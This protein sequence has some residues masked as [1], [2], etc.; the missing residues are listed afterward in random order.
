MGDISFIISP[1]GESGQVNFQ[2]GVSSFFIFNCGDFYIAH[3][4]GCLNR[5]GVE[6]T[7]NFSP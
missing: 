3:K 4:K 1:T 6:L 5:V 2:F 7:L